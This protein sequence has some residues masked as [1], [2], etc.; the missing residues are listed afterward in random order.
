[1]VH[2][3]DGLD[4]IS[5]GAPTRVAELKDGEVREFTVTPEDFGLARSGLEALAVDSVEKS[6]ATLRAVL[7]DVPGP[8]RD[9]VALNAGAA[10]A[11]AALAG[12]LA[13]GV[14]AARD[15]LASGAARARLEALA[16]LSNRL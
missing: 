5:I 11:A 2:A 1:V 8:A 14:A 15:A 13:E 3:D 6:L 16:E 4:E 9:V 7:A 12:T 10:I